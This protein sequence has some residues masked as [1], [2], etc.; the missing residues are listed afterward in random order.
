MKIK[1]NVEVKYVFVFFVLIVLLIGSAVYAFGGNNPSVMGHG[2]G[3]INW[4]DT[5]SP[6][7]ISQ[8]KGAKGNTGPQ[9]DKGDSGGVANCRLEF[10]A[11]EVLQLNGYEGLRYCGGNK[12]ATGGYL[13]GSDMSV[14]KLHC[15][16]VRIVC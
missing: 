15:K 3:E 7:L 9:G 1:I 4:G 5:L 2:V 6:T 16:D 13:D 11:A 10:G 12:V 8:L 14:E